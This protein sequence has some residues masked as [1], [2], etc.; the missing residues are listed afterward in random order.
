[1]KLTMK[2]MALAMLMPLMAA[3][4]TVDIDEVSMMEIENWPFAKA[5]HQEYV[6]LAYA[7]AAEKDWK[8]ANF[9]AAK[10]EEIA[11]ADFELPGPQAVEDRDISEDA[12]PDLTGAYAALNEALDSGRRTKPQAAARAQAMFD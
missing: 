1:M 5:L 3:C 8:D 4:G 6:D 7:E 12:L 2:A 10:A 9:F 11:M